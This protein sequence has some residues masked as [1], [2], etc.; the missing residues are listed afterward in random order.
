M[1]EGYRMLYQRCCIALW[2]TYYKKAWLPYLW[3]SSLMYNTLDHR[4]LLPTYCNN[5]QFQLIYPIQ[6]K[7]SVRSRTIQST[8]ET[9]YSRHKL[10]QILDD[11]VAA[12]GTTEDKN[13]IR[14]AEWQI[15]FFLVLFFRF[16]DLNWRFDF[17]IIFLFQVKLYCT[18]YW[19]LHYQANYQ[20]NTV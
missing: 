11:G 18:V 5:R 14:K 9:D 1:D 8:K 12:P 10:K 7:F 6:T 20:N 13:G 2:D 17:V 15:F 19:F 3:L 16:P 4:P